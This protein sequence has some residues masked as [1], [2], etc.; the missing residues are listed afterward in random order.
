[1]LTLDL[2]K[3]NDNLVVHG[4]LIV[5]LSTNVSQPISN[6][7]PSAVNGLSAAL[8]NMGIDDN[9]NLSPGVSSSSGNAL[10]RTPSHQTGQVTPQPEVQATIQMPTPQINRSPTATASGTPGAESID[11]AVP[12]SRPVSGTVTGNAAPTANTTVPASPTTASTGQ[13]PS[14]VPAGAQTSAAPVTRN[15]NPTEDH[16]GP[17]PPGWERRIDRLGRTY[18]VDHTYVVHSFIFPPVDIISDKRFKLQ[19]PQYD[20]AQALN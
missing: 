9:A 7:G 11:S 16:I 5:Y 10:S 1:M 18:Y 20:L 3:S 17:L 6:P 12:S 19:N 8:A 15:F 4:K 2:K 13:L 14:A